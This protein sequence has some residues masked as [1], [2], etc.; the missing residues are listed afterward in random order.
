MWMLFQYLT[1][2]QRPLMVRGYSEKL[3]YTLSSR[4]PSS[5]GPPNFTGTTECLVRQNQK[6]KVHWRYHSVHSGMLPCPGAPS[7]CEG[8]VCYQSGHYLTQ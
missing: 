5:A 3:F 8:L 6:K 4:S 7:P 2:Y 1:F